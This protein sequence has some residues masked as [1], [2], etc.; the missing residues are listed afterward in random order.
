MTSLILQNL[1][2]E[3][4]SRRSMATGM[5]TM[6]ERESDFPSKLSAQL[7]GIMLDPTSAEYAD[8][9]LD[10]SWNLDSNR[11]RNKFSTSIFADTVDEIIIGSGFHAAVYA[12]SRVLAGFPKPLV[13]ERSN[14][15]GGVF[16]YNR[17]VFYLN[18]RTRR[19][20]LGLSG[21][22]MANLNYLPGAPIQT[23]NLATGEYQT[24]LDIARVIRLTL[25]EYANVLPA[26]AIT[27]VTRER[28]FS[29]S[30]TYR[31]AAGG[32]TYNT[33]RI[34]DARGL[35]DPKDTS[36][37]NGN[38]IL[39][40][41][42]LMTRMT[43]RW[44]LRG[45]TSAAVIGGGD[46]ARCAIE[47][48]LGIAPSAMMGSFLDTVG[49]VD[50]YS[51][52]LPNTFEGWCAN[53]RGRYRPIGQFLKPDQRGVSRL[54]VFNNTAFPINLPGQQA[55]VDGRS[56]DLVVMATGSQLPDIDGINRFDMYGY[57]G[58]EIT[59]FGPAEQLCIKESGREIYR[60]GPAANLQFTSRERQAGINRVSNNRVAM[61]RLAP[62]TATLASLLPS[63]NNS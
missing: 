39:T 10:E 62:K 27:R 32:F 21:D 53:E 14:R 7:T 1:V 9:L 61:F 63:P 4:G 43:D 22:S 40:F 8:N 46:A 55:V 38:N 15:V 60:I 12:A 34:I 2:K 33:R 23:S 47:S 35:G 56:Y 25:A 18:S 11:I 51:D 57:Q 59:Q 3:I 37:T 49:R 20:T 6:M 44:P 16:S 54:N 36:R 29:G 19:G 41:D 30:P 52:K 50:A 5:R 24:N 42:Q 31:V 26:S 28:E 17:P 45:I 58:N 13:I 48:L